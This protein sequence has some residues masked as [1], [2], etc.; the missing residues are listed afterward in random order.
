MSKAAFI[1]AVLE[2]IDGKMTKTA[3]VLF[4]EAVFEAVM[5]QLRET[6]DFSLRD[7]GTFKIVT[8]EA[9]VGRNP[10]SGEKVD[11]P[12]KRIIKF[13]AAPALEKSIN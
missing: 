8:R 4:V 11:I 1:E 5:D 12:S 2:K 13:K 10:R 7:F 3:T 9:R 6:G